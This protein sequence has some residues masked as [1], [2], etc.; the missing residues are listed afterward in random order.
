MSVGPHNTE[1]KNKTGEGVTRSHEI[2]TWRYFSFKW[3]AYHH[4]SR[5]YCHI[6]VVK[7]TRAHH[8]TNE[9]ILPSII[10]NIHLS[11]Y[12]S[13]YIYTVAYFSHSTLIC[14]RISWNTPLHLHGRW[15][16]GSPQIYQICYLSILTTEYVSAYGAEPPG[17]WFY[18][19]VVYVSL[20]TPT[21]TKN[22][23]QL[24]YNHSPPM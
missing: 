8:D 18:C 21:L 4:I 20:Q 6:N 11:I 12:L 14:Y 3:K 2:K 19:C 9:Q 1:D 15:I 24:C 13:V 22:T 23:S 16:E 7:T 5:V 17:T 10:W